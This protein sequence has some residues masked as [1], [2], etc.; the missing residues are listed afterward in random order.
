MAYLITLLTIKQHRAYT[1]GPNKALVTRH[2]WQFVLLPT[3]EEKCWMPFVFL[4][5]EK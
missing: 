3:E 1:K 4:L 5:K 2:P